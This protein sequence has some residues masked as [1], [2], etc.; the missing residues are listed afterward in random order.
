M[1]SSTQTQSRRVDATLVHPAVELRLLGGFKLLKHNQPLSVR[2]GGK[3]EVLL[4]NLALRLPGGMDRGELLSVLWPASDEAL[5]SQSLD[6]LVH[7]L[8][9]A[10][11]DALGGAAPVV[12]T[13]GRLRLNTELGIGVDIEAF[14]SEASHGDRLRRAGSP[15]EAM[16]CYE[17]AASLY[18]GDLVVGS[19]IRHLLERERLR[20]RYLELLANLAVA[21][22]EM[23]EYAA[24][25]DWAQLLLQCDPC[26]EDAHRLVMRCDVR[27]GRRAQALRQYATCVEIL[28]REFTADPEP[29]TRDL[30]ESVRTTPTSV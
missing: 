18:E 1:D 24:S 30:Y 13:A 27:L 25:R 19:E 21:Q 23:G 29:A 10:V 15:A 5:A 26:R 7:S 22:F 8:R 3:T 6:T 14:E 28:R 16:T 2:P 20:A 12:R 17:R 4:V 9:R 11:G